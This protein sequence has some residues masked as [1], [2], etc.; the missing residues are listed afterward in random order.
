MNPAETA[1]LIALCAFMV[2][3]LFGVYLKEKFKQ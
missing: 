2:G 3:T 1:T